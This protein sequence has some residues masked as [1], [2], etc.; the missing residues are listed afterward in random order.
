MIISPTASHPSAGSP[1]ILSFF[2]IFMNRFANSANS[3][4]VDYKNRPNQ[5]RI[6]STNRPPL[7]KWVQTSSLQ[8]GDFRINWRKLRK[9]RKS[10]FL[11]ENFP[12]TAHRVI[13]S[14][15]NSLIKAFRIFFD[16]ENVKSYWPDDIYLL[17]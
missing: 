5:K 4:R 16:H 7:L 9:W 15:R 12:S 6:F 13:P 1:I 8:I 3:N 10:W 2:I 17:M 14:F 11:A